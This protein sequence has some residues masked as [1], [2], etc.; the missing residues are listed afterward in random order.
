VRFLRRTAAILAA[1]ILGSAT[2]ILAQT[3]VDRQVEAGWEALRQG[4]GD[5][6]ATVF[7][8][9]LRRNPREAAFHFGAGVAAHL[10][11][12]ETD[13]I[14]SLT[15]ALELD[16]KLT[17]AS[18]LLGQLHY[19]QGDL[20]AAIRVYEQ[21]LPAAA[22]PP[23]MR[24]RLDEWR[25]E[26]AVHAKLAVRND[27]RFTIIFDGQSDQ[28]LATRASAVLERAFWTIG[29][30]IGTYPSNRIIV[31]L[32]TEQQ[33]R[34]IT[35]V[36]AWSSGAFD[37]KIRIPVKGVS[38]NL[39]EFD[40]V[41]L[42]EL[43]HAIVHALAPRGVP[44]WLHEGLATYFEPRD[45]ALAQRR[46]QAL[47]AVIPLSA[48]EG[49]FSRLDAT[50][51]AVAYGQSL[52]AADMLMRIV[53][54]RMGVLLQALGSGQSFDTSLGQLGMRAADFETQLARRLKP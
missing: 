16:P 50:Q 38:Q 30:K 10:Q 32:Y 51:A 17:Q 26:A 48:L 15:R 40:H 21:A 36:P 11:R 4:D 49:S 37:G 52:V 42:H 9:L 7:S 28:T 14:A 22:G 3:A 6:A 25:K 47:G 8:E 46:L 18:D 27:A 34:D 39:D 43:T 12:R 44:A 53:S 5:K 31:T 24:T 19:L 29:Q 20:D 54:G 45:P 2:P 13:A 35:R 33:F 1:V 23:A 41:L